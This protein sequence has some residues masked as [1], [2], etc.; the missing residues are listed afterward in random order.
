MIYKLLILTALAAGCAGSPLTS[1]ER[2]KW[3]SEVEFIEVEWRDDACYFSASDVAATELF[4]P[5]GLR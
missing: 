3:C 4:S 2:R 5:A 1:D